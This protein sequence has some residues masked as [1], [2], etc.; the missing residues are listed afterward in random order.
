M[1]TEKLFRMSKSQLEE[2]INLENPNDVLLTIEKSQYADFIDEDD[3]VYI[4]YQ[5]ERIKYHLAK[6]FMYFSDSTGY[7]LYSFYLF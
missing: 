3:Y 4:E 1:I 7:S 6:R 5:A 2:L